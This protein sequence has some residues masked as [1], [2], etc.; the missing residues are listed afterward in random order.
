MTSEPG[1]PTLQA[2]REPRPYRF[3]IKV[4]NNRL[5]VAIRRVFPTVT[6]QTQAARLLGIHNGTLTSLLNMKYLP[7][8]FPKPGR[9]NRAVFSWHK[10]VIHISNRLRE[11]CEYLFDPQL[12]GKTFPPT[13]LELGLTSA[14]LAD[15]GLLALPPAPDDVADSHL[16]RDQIRHAVSQLPSRDQVVLAMRFGL[17]GDKPKT[18]QEASDKLGIS[19]E[20]IRRSEL[21]AL[22]RLRHPR[23]SKTLKQH[24]P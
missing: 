9:G 13:E 16:L 14:Q 22:R 24:L 19:R 23:L 8:R 17:N 2:A 6:T 11:T 1:N 5:W 12:Y 7:C 18:L 4:K 20:A 10:T 15:H 3:Q 21:A